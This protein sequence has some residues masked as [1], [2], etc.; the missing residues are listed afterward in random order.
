[1]RRGLA[2]IVAA[3]TA[4][5]FCGA[6]LGYFYAESR[7]ALIVEAEGDLRTIGSEAKTEAIDP[8][9]NRALADAVGARALSIF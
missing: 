1:M 3:L 7:D 9:G 6:V 2:M 5:A 4:L 8:K